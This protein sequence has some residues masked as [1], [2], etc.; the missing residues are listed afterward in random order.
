MKQGNTMPR[1]DYKH[2]KVDLKDLDREAVVIQ[3]EEQLDSFF[4]D[5]DMEEAVNVSVAEKVQGELME[6]NDRCKR[7]DRG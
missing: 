5:F 6:M 1:E 4:D 7:M 3:I 2:K